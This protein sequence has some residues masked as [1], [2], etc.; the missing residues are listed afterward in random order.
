MGGAR[1]VSHTSKLGTFFLRFLTLRM[2]TYSNF[3]I[4]EAAG[5]TAFQ[6]MQLF[7]TFIV[8]NS[9]IFLKNSFSRSSIY[10]E[11]AIS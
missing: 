4:N 6:K 11:I 3:Q 2:S 10:L 7:T 5:E 9:L 8:V 1:G